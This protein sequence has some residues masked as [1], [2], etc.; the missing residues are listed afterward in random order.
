[1]AATTT[2]VTLRQ[3]R[4]VQFEEILKRGSFQPENRD[5]KKK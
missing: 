1:M 2:A 3:Q 4:V 5:R